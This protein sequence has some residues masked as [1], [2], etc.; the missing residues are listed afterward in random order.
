M[1]KKILIPLDGSPEAAAILPTALAFARARYAELVLVRVTADYR[2]DAPANIAARQELADIAREYGLDDLR[3]QTALRYGDVGEQIVAAA[4]Q[5]D[6][7]L[8]ALATHGRHGFARAWYGSVAEHVLAASPV[9]VLLLRSD[10]KASTKLRTVLVPVDNSPG[11]VA[12]L[13]QAR[14]LAALTHAHLVLLEVIAPLHGWDDN[15]ELAPEREDELRAGAQGFM[16][17][18]ARRQR[19]HGVAATGVAATGPV[20][21]TI[22][23]VARERDA[24]LIVLGT[25]GLIG[26]RR[27]LLGSVADA[28][29][30]TAGLPV[31]L[32]RQGGAAAPRIGEE[33]VADSASVPQAH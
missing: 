16:D 25:H 9:P 13:A 1:F 20:A 32:I 29:V 17:Q 21:E 19:E 4:R 2:D 31:L 22:G 7:D 24:D 15:P 33:R 18:L 5:A 10:G 8:L 27:A 28:V 6:A 3:V 26:P 11:S 12:A 30:R 23:R 14:E